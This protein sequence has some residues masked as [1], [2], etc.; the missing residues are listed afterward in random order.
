[1]ATKQQNMT[2]REIMESLDKLPEDATIDD[3]IEQL[4]FMIAVEH[5]LADLEAGRVISH[6]ELVERV[7]QWLK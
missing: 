6:D 4:C 1:M 7:K 2:K 5:G 3:F